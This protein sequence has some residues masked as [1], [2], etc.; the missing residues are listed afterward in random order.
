MKAIIV[1]HPTQK[2][3]ACLFGIEYNKL[4]KLAELRAKNKQT[5]KARFKTISFE[6]EFELAKKTENITKYKITDE[7]YKHEV[8]TYFEI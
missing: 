2:F 7:V 6:N 5:I 3:K 1:T 8:L 4:C